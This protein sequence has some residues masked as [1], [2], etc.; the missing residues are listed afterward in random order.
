AA[1]TLGGAVCDRLAAEG[2]SV[3]AVAHGAAD[4]LPAIA[5]HRLGGVDLADE[6]ATERAFAKLADAAADNV[7]GLVNAAGSFAWEAITGGRKAT[8]DRL[9]ATNLVTALNAT[10]AVL[11]WLR[12]GGAIVNVGAAAAAKA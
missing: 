8:W 9:Y 1:G 12:D 5:T 2:W 10:R 3:A 4:T 6:E 11:P 7:R